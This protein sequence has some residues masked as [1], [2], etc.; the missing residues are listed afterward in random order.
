MGYS[1]QKTCMYCFAILC[2]L[3]TVSLCS[4]WFYQ[5]TLNK[6][7]SVVQYKEF[8][9]ANDGVFPTASLC[10]GNPFLKK[11]LD[12]YGV[13]ETSYLAFL[14]GESFTK[15]MLNINFSYVT[16]DITDYINGYLFAF[17]NGTRV[18]FSSGL[19]LQQ[20][21]MITF[22]SFSG[23]SGGANAFYKCFALKTPT[24]NKN[25]I[26]ICSEFDA[27]GKYFHSTSK[28]FQFFEIVFK[29]SKNNFQFIEFVY[30]LY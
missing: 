10:L 7:L 1:K 6:D 16:I 21:K 15:E 12:E 2:G 19:S 8:E 11:K 14:R 5:F 26:E 24:I 30:V 17:N 28:G 29:F 13:N 22:P 3:A 9:G 20:K 18:H 4:Y 23:F 27:D 25:I